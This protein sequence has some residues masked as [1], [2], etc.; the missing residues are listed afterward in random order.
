MY[1]IFF[2]LNWEILN[3]ISSIPSCQLNILWHDS[4]V[5]PWMAHRF[6]SSNRL[7]TY[8]STAFCRARRDIAWTLRLPHICWVISLTHFTNG[9]FLMRNEVNFWNFLISC[10]ATIPGLYLLFLLL[11]PAW[12]SPLTFHHI[13]LLPWIQLMA[14][15][16]TSPSSCLAHTF[17]FI[18]SVMLQWCK[19]DSCTRY[20][21]KRVPMELH[22]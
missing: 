15:S 18:Y 17:L 1:L 20:S 10:K 19:F 8:A 6:A 12:W 13:F 7:T 4:N 16:N 9:S 21:I 11:S 2:N 22:F 14:P 5:F 3:H